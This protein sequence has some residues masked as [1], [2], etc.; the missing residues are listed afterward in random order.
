MSDYTAIN[1]QKE[2]IEA[3]DQARKKDTFKVTRAEFIRRA[4]RGFLKELDLK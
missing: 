1:L 4:I 3:V 2:Y